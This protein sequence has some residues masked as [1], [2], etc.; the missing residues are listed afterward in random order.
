MIDIFLERSFYDNGLFLIQHPT[1]NGKTFAMEETVVK[2]LEDIEKLG[3]RKIIILTG[4]KVNSKPVFKNIE[5]KLEAKGIG[6]D[7][8]LYLNSATE[9]FQEEEFLKRVKE[10][11]VEINQYEKEVERKLH[12]FDKERQYYY[13]YYYGSLE[14]ENFIFS[15]NIKRLIFTFF[16]ILREL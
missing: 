14:E 12:R 15:P 1:G 6:K 11:L 8:I 2:L 13:S 7:K 3:E 9:K 10:N 5:K 4:N 16:L